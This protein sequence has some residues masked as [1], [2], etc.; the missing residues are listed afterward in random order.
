M[1]KNNDKFY[2]GIK[3]PKETRKNLLESSKKIIEN[4]KDY[5]T[6]ITIREEKSKKV[7]E[8][9][10][11]VDEIVELFS[12][13]KKKLPKQGIHH[14]EKDAKKSKKGK[15]KIKKSSIKDDEITR[16][17]NDLAEIESRLNSM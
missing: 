14:E 17:E 16:L 6:I 2:V 4:L 12:Y 11:K 9:M 13:L 8:F 1:A 10:E 3:K 7:D 15:D 5:D